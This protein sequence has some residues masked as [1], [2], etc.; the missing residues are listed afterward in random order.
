MRRLNSAA[1]GFRTLLGGRSPPRAS[2]AIRRRSIFSRSIRAGTTQRFWVAI[3]EAM[4]PYT[5][6]NILAAVDMKRD[7]SGG[8]VVEAADARL[9]ASS[10]CAPSWSRPW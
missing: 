7:A 6:R 3:K 5:D 10:C 2:R 8:I 9:T 4:P 1:S